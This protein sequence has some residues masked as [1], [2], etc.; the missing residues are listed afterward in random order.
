MGVKGLFYI[1]KNSF[2]FTNVG[3][4]WGKLKGFV[5]L[6]KRYAI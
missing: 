3:K 4:M 5:Y 6:Q 1:Y 2:V